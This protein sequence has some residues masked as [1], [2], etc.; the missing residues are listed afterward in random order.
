MTESPA[1]TP[2]APAH[3]A[4]GV[5]GTPGATASV[6][7]RRCP[8]CG[9]LPLGG[10]APLPCPRCGADV[11]TPLR[12]R[13]PGPLAGLLGV[14]HCI[15]FL[16]RHPRLWGWIVIPLLLNA[17]IFAAIF[18]WTMGQADRFVPDLVTPWWAWIDWLRVGLSYV[19]PTLM[20]IVAVLACLI[21][22]LLV[23]SIVNAPFYDMLSERTEVFALGKPELSRPWSRFLGD[24]TRSVWAATI[25]AV[26]QMIVMTILFALSFT[27]IGAPLFVAAGFFYTGLALMDVP[28]SRKLY[29]GGERIRWGRRHIPH[30]MG[31]GLPVNL[32]PPLAPLGIVGATLAYLDHPDKG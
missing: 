2:P 3:D 22:T 21:A 25:L 8:R 20:G 6:A 30:L 18:L 7:P 10:A 32:L 17:C 16:N 29:N 1:P 9:L 27:A 12:K 19:L 31:L 15:R 5:P 23:S 24:V 11:S 4:A 28:L 26:R 14:L 13:P